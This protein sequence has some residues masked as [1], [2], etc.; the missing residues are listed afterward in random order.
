M[1]RLIQ[2]TPSNRPE[3]FRLL[4][5]NPKTYECVG[6]S[7]D[8][9]FEEITEIPDGFEQRVLPPSY[10]IQLNVAQITNGLL[11]QEQ[12]LVEIIRQ[13]SDLDFRVTLLEL[14]GTE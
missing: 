9:S 7:S 2:T 14:G 11:L 8:T 5:Q 1:N 12:G 4:A 3:D 13:N 6:Y 10:G